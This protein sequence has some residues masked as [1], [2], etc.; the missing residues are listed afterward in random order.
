MPGHLNLEPPLHIKRHLLMRFF[1]E[2]AADS[3]DWTM[4][5]EGDESRGSNY[6]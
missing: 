3:W 6:F 1:E 2:V 5:P 4:L